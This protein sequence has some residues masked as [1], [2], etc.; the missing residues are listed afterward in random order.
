M[1]SDAMRLRF[2]AFYFGLAVVTLSTLAGMAQSRTATKPVHPAPN[3]T[4]DALFKK[5]SPSVFGV[6]R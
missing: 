3:L 5:V 6:Y 2:L 1:E 4:P